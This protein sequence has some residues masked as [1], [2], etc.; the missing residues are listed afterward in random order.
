[1]SYLIDTDW[2]V[3]HLLG[4]PAA[5]Q[6]LGSLEPDGLAISLDTFGEIYEGI[7]HGTD[8]VQAEAVFLDF[9]GRVDVIG[10]DTEVFKLYAT[11]RGRLRSIG[12]LV[13]EFDLLIAATAIHHDLILVC[14]NLR[15]YRRILG[16]KLH[17]GPGTA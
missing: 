17:Q 8:P 10:L 14:R 12:Q 7:Y 4:K 3:D 16:L 11:I 2:V 1:V 6:L 5:I 9:L 13:A 15:H